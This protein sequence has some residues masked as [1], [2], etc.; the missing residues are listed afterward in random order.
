MSNCHPRTQRTLFNK[1]CRVLAQ[2]PQVE[3]H[4]KQLSFKLSSLFLIPSF[5]PLTIYCGPGSLP[6][7]F[8]P[9][10]FVFLFRSSTIRWPLPRHG[11]RISLVQQ[12]P[13]IRHK[14]INYDSNKRYEAM[15]ICKAWVA[16]IAPFPISVEAILH[17]RCIFVG[18]LW[19]S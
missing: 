7:Y 14:C 11:H 16:Q 13:K 6:H 10:M 18:C 4:P 9:F 19:W 15:E 12:V 3:H 5:S 1:I 2:T 8:Y 17:L